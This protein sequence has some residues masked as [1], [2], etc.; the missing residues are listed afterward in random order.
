MAACKLASKGKTMADGTYEAEV[1]SITAFLNMQRP[2]QIA[3][4]PNHM[5]IQPEEFVAPKFFRRIKTKQV[6]VTG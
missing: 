6:G 2:K 5:D 1:Q 3:V 4:D